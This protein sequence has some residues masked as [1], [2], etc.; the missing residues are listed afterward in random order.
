MSTILNP[1]TLT[2]QHQ[3]PQNTPP[4]FSTDQ[5]FIVKKDL[6]GASLRKIEKF[7]RQDEGQDQAFEKVWIPEDQIKG[8]I[9][10]INEDSFEKINEHFRLDFKEIIEQATCLSELELV[11]VRRNILKKDEEVSMHR[12]FEGYV[13]IIDLPIPTQP[14]G[15]PVP[16]PAD[17]HRTFQGGNILFTKDNGEIVEIELKHDELFVGKC[18]N[19]HGVQKVLSGT[20]ESIALFSRPK[21]S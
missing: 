3:M 11:A 5:Y 17:S 13:V 7:V 10:K 1:L 19:Y 8:K 15:E 2:N 6:F 21:A 20:R 14:E 9:H 4:S 12:D 18:T 16:Q